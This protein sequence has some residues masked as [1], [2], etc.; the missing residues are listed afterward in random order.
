MF[1][2][3][4]RQLSRK[5]K[6]SNNRNKARIKVARVHL[7]ITNQRTDFLHKT[8][9]LLAKEYSVINVE[10]LNIQNMIKNHHLAKSISDA[11]WGKFV[12]MLSY[13]EL[14]LG[15][16]VNKVNPKFT[17]QDCSKCGTRNKIKLSEIIYC[18]K[19]CGS[20]M[21]RDANASDNVENRTQGHWGTNTPVDIRPPHQYLA[22]ASQMKEAGTIIE[23]GI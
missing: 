14:A 15:G 19:H 17:T 5:V 22:G 6:G 11:G 13:K 21:D 12:E 10:K 20:L 2:K 4:Q 18:C 3:S 9:S 8:T 23:D 7:K 16:Q 1:V